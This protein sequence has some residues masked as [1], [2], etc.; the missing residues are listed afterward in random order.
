MFSTGSGS[1]LTQENQCSVRYQ[2]ADWHTRESVFSTVSGSWLTYKRANV[3]YGVGQLT[4]IQE[5]QFSVRC[6]AADWR[7][8]KPVFITAS[9]SWLA[10]KKARVHSQGKATDMYESHGSAQGQAHR[11]PECGT[12]VVLGSGFRSQPKDR[13]RWFGFFCDCFQSHQT[14]GTRTSNWVVASS[15]PVCCSWLIILFLDSIGFEQWT[16]PVKEPRIN[17]CLMQTLYLSNKHK[18]SPP[19][20]S[21]IGFC[22]R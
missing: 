20:N 19:H 1:W 6:Q 14:C 4:D 5:S 10:W 7:A 22:W 9:D 8:R 11:S 21:Y 16:A 18:V 17:R 15:F 2:A 13:L 3:Q 12:S